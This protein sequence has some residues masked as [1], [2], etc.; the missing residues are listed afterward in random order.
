MGP[1]EKE[2]HPQHDWGDADID[3][4]DKVYSGSDEEEEGRSD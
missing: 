1:D 3:N 2:E 4:N